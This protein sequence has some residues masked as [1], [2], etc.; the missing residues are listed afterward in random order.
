[1]KNKQDQPLVTICVPV[2]NGD[3]YLYECLNSISLQSYSNWECVVNNNC[4]TDQSLE[5]AQDFA[6]NDVRFKVYTNEV[7]IPVVP[8]WNKV[9]F[10]A[11]KEAKYLKF[12]QADDWIYPECI[13][14]M[15]ELCETDPNI[16]LC[17][18][19]RIDSIR[20]LP[21]NFNIYDG[22][23]FDGKEILYKHLSHQ[24]DIV[25]SITTVMFSMQYLKKIDRF[26]AIFDESNYHIDSELDYEIMYMSRVGFV[27]Q[28]LTYTRRHKESGTSTVV[29]RLGTLNQH[30]ELVLS[31]YKDIHPNVQLLYNKARLDYAYFYGKSLLLRKTKTIEWHK[32]YYK[33]HFSFKEY[34]IGFI[35]RNPFLE[36]TKKAL[37]K[38]KIL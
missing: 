13:E 25:G 9:F 23:V 15:V 14:R 3:K 37:K 16:G 6:K 33:G 19:Y 31:R 2:Y 34:L 35:T 20:V 12:V 36:F 17:S 29:Y 28:I 4:S 18:S 30:N 26:P 10:H 11:N 24:L 32:K 38:L 7:F 21:L 8:N 22:R 27:P 5:I 1:M